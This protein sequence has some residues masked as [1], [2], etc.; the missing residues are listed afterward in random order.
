MRLRRSTLRLLF[1]TARDLGLAEGD[2]TMDVVLPSRTNEAAR[3][4]TD[5]EVQRCRRA[6][7]ED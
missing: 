3:L 4:L 7:L 1:R 2:P 6:A 5:L